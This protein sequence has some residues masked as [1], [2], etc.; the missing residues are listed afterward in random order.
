MGCLID[1][2][3]KSQLNVG[4]MLWLSILTSP[5]T[6]TLDFLCQIL[7][8]MERKGYEL[9]R[10]Y[11]YFVTLS[12]DFDLGF[13]RSYFENAVSK[14]WKVQVTWKQMDVS[15]TMLDSHCS[16][17]LWPHPWPFFSSVLIN[18]WSCFTEFS[19]FPDLW[20][21]EQFPIS[22]QPALGSISTL[23]RCIHYFCPG[24]INFWSHC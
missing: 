7:I 14:E 19:S 9:I 12:Y 16:L 3:R 21:F 13:S 20:L 18:L 10:C 17:E 11:T 6:L 4:P 1:I 24:L 23:G 2:E 8:D 15:D 22:G 5:M